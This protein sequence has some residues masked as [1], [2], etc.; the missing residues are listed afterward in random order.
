MKCP[1]SSSLHITKTSCK[2]KV[3][4]DEDDHVPL[5]SPFPLPKH[6]PYNVKTALNEKK[7][8]KDTMSKFISMIA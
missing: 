5:P 1:P 2:S 3:K 6:Y 7:M 4:K 8:T